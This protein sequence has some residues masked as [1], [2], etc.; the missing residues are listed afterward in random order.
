M[1]NVLFPISISKSSFG[2]T[3]LVLLL[4]FQIPSDLFMSLSKALSKA[5]S[6]VLSDSC[7][8]EHGGARL[9]F[10]TSEVF[11]GHHAV[12]VS[13]PNFQIELSFPM[14][15]TLISLLET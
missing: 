7:P 4:D 14:E 2:S 13:F 3:S 9:H 8:F 12:R 6:K 10:Q 15:M 5:L 11:F 1:I